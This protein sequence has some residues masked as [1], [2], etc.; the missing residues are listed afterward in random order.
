MRSIWTGSISFG[1]VNVPVRM[2]TATESKELRS[3][4][5]HRG[6]FAPIGYDVAR[7]ERSR[8]TERRPAGKGS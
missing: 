1:L 4:S 6:D 8:S 3:H 7:T 2:F 5:L